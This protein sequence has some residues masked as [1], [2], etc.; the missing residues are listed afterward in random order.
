MGSF[1]ASIARLKRSLHPCTPDGL[2]F[3]P[4]GPRR[5]ETCFPVGKTRKNPMGLKLKIIFFSF[6]NRKIKIAG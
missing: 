1:A 3:M 2:I 4:I 6:L 5:R